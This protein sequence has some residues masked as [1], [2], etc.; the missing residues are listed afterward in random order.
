MILVAAAAAHREWPTRPFEESPF[1]GPSSSLPPHLIAR[2]DLVIAK[3]SNGLHPM[4]AVYG[5]SCL[6]PLEQ[7]I[8]ARNLKIQDL[9]SQAA[10]RIR[11]VTATDLGAIDPTARSFHNVN[12]PADL[13]AA[14]SFAARSGQ[15]EH[16]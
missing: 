1:I 15:P 4:H 5:K 13:E 8:A 11:I 7:M 9:A 10:L 2:A 3:L 14:R 6:P 12:T 16:Q